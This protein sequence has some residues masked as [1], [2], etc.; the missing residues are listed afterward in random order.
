[1][2]LW[3]LQSGSRLG[4]LVERQTVDILLPIANGL[5]ITTEIISG[6]LPDGLR[7]VDNRILGTPFEVQYDT[8]STFVVRASYNG[9]IDDRTFDILVTG[10]DEPIWQ[11]PEGFL[12][13][14]PGDTNQYWF[15]TAQSSYSL[16]ISDGFNW[17]P[18]SLTKYFG[19]PTLLEGS[20]G[21]HAIDLGSNVVQYYLK[22]NNRWKTLDTRNFNFNIAVQSTRPD[23]ARTKYWFRVDPLFFNPIVQNYDLNKE[24]WLPVTTF[25]D[26]DPPFNVNE[27]VL[28]VQVF[29]NEVKFIIKR[30]NNFE[31]DYFPLNYKASDS[32]PSRTTP[33]YY[34]LDNEPVDFQLLAT[35]NDL[36]AGEE[37]EYFLGDRA[38]ELPP[39][40]ELTLDGRLVG[41]VEP[42]LSLDKRAGAGNYDTHVYGNFPYDYAV[43]PSNGYASYYYDLNTYDYA[44]TTQSPRKLNRYYQ[45]TVTVTDGDSF[46]ERDFRIY[47]VGDDF[48]RADNTI[49][50]AGTGIFTADVTHIREPIWLTP[51]DLGVRRANNYLTFYLDVIDNETLSGVT[52]YTLDDFNDDG[53]PS[54]LPP[55]MKLDGVI[56]EVVGRVPYQPAISKDYK[57]TVRA[58][59]FTGDIETVTVFAN[60][61]EDTLLG[62]N[63]FKV[64]NLDLTGS[65]DGVYDLTELVGRTIKLENRGYK[66]INVDSSP[67]DHDVIFLDD[68]IAPSISLNIAKTANPGSLE[69]Y[70]RRLGNEDREKYQ[71]RTIKFS[72]TEEYKI[73]SITPYIEYLIDNKDG[74][75]LYPDYVPEPWESAFFYQVDDIV[76]YD[77]V[78]YICTEAHL[79]SSGDIAGVGNGGTFVGIDSASQWTSLGAASS[80]LSLEYR[81]KAVKSRLT[82][83]YG[84]QGTVFVEPLNGDS[85]TTW[86]IRMPSTSNSRIKENIRKQ[87]ISRSGDSSV[88]NSPIDV[89]VVNDNQDRITIDVALSRTLAQGRN[90]GIGLFKNDFF[91]VSFPKADTDDEVNVPSKSKTFTVKIIGEVDSTIEF[92][93]PSDLG[94]I[95]ANFTSILSVKALTT[96]PDSKLTYT[97]TRGKLP[98]GLI[99]NYNGELIGKPKQYGEPGS[100]GLTS[101]DN[102]LTRFDGVFPTATTFDRTYKFTVKAEDRYK[103][104]SVEK[105]FSVTVLDLDNTLYSNIY[106]RPFME[107]SKRDT[108]LT[109]VGNT[110]VFT[111][112]YIYRPDD[113]E[114]GIQRKLQML[115]YAGIESKDISEFVAASA[116]N[117]KRKRY[118]IGDV[119]TA[120]ARLPGSNETIYEVVY[121]DVKDPAKPK[122]GKARESF[123]IKNNKKITADSIQYSVKDDETRTGSGVPELPIFGRETV[124]FVFVENEELIIETRGTKYEIDADN[125]DFLLTLRDGSEIEI[126]LQINNSEPFRFRPDT[127]TI[128]VDS[129]AIDIS[130]SSD[131][132]KFISNIDNMRN[133]I[134]EIGK[135]ER[136]Y[137]PLWMRTPQGTAIQE[138]DYITAIPLCYCKPGTSQEILLNIQNE[139]NLG[140]VDFKEIDFEI[141]RYIVDSTEGNSNEQYILFANYQFN[142]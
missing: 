36:P 2:A 92:L 7:L 3:N 31:Q 81:V 65:S 30:Y 45:F 44:E 128:K 38:G 9:E 88:D 62:N 142:V 94:S 59:R 12:P 93:T 29:P 21:D 64:Y 118:L 75:E 72:E 138:L 26:F 87:F 53:T 6:K 50:Q 68:T 99:L 66:V 51:R 42:L 24:D 122:E 78:T 126:D 120:V 48:L 39:G 132:K 82:R 4:L 112:E 43:P 22:D 83:L 141:D 67:Q 70:V 60:Y 15:D 1:M 106:A 80:A 140:N 134:E 136:N 86:R 115:I 73:E 8:T 130:A 79:S 135:N 13:L 57:F 63:S 47:L 84:S 123:F 109:F 74:E 119:K 102:N 97:L 71:S 91:S 17:S 116:K 10:P 77:G 89:A 49:M 61:F 95:N 117:H 27:T 5:D 11:T 37:L 111:P 124:K 127:N 121:L 23:P 139:I 125:E 33:T 40:L 69:F 25:I 41:I 34:V 19:I 98:N 96:V 32:R 16:Y 46:V 90:I 104:S 54:E 131:V 133:R 18:V 56:G 20:N 14:G 129:N 110:D 85:L 108:Y 113:P 114:F 100:P 58:T 101:F 103:L 76:F 52:L 107:R 105:E 28:W 137:L 55:G 35:D